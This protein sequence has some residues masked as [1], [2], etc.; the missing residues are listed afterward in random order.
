MVLVPALFSYREERSFRSLTPLLCC[1]AVLQK[2]CL[3]QDMASQDAKLLR[4]PKLGP[5][6]LELAR[7]I[8]CRLFPLQEFRRVRWDCQQS[9]WL[10]ILT[11]LL[12]WGNLT[13]VLTHFGWSTLPSD[14]TL[15]GDLLPQN[16][17][18][19]RWRVQIPIALES[20][21]WIW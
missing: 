17:L 4:R 13:A 1:G 9:S 7:W 12:M 11:T 20:N 2:D 3:A 5:T 21:P 6:K 15:R 14:A 19:R 18:T 8:L 16:F 10:R